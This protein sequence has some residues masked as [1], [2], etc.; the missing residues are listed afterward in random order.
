[1]TQIEGNPLAQDSQVDDF[2]RRDAAKALG[3]LGRADDAVLEGLL[4]L[5]RNSQ[6]SG[7]VRRES[8]RSLKQLVGGD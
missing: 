2:V 3:Q 1:V 6:V 5:A 4:A 8:Y 7:L